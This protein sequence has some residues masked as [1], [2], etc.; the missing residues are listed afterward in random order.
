MATLLLSK[1]KNSFELLLDKKKKYL[2]AYSG[3]PD[4]TFLLYALKE[5]GYNNITAYYINYHDSP[6]V[7]Q[8]KNIVVKNLLSFGIKNAT[9]DSIHSAKAFKGQNF[10]EAARTARYRRFAS[11]IRKN[12]SVYEACL[13]AH[14]LDDSLITYMMQKEKKTLTDTA[15]ISP[16]A[17]LSGVKIIRPLL[18]VRKKEILGFLDYNKIPYYTDQTNN[19]LIRKR[20]YL[21]LNVL[22]KMSDEEIDK[23]NG[24]MK[25]RQESI[26]QEEGKLLML[27]T[28]T[29]PYKEYRAL[30]EEEKRRLLFRWCEEQT[31]KP[32]SQK[33]LIASRNLA[34]ENLKGRNS[35]AQV[36]LKGGIS[37]YRNY[38]DF[39]IMKTVAL[40][41][42]MFL[43]QSIAPVDTPLFRMNFADLSLLNLKESDFPLLIRNVRMDDSFGTKI[44]SDSVWSFLKKQKVPEYLRPFYPVIE[45]KQGKIVFVPFYEDLKEKKI[46]LVFKGFI[47]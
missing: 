44:I 32:Y 27:R 2:V 3:G 25:N 36:V 21:R 23:L 10:E 45:N 12:G 34:Y 6:T 4:S 22:D 14:H 40:K 28:I 18:D 46:P 26:R 9:F 33:V 29:C 30:H 39:Y 7:S 5:L 20:N 35:T 42:Y 1:V 37:L 24:E 13:T 8:E 11:F 47:L 17:Y 15:G 38:E 16:V 19:S 31:P 43:V 41:P